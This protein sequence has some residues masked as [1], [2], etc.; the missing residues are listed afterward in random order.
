M[1]TEEIDFIKSFTKIHL[2]T[3]SRV[4]EELYKNEWSPACERL[5]IE[6]RNGIAY[7]AENILLKPQMNF[8]PLTRTFKKEQEPIRQ[9]IDN[10]IRQI[11]NEWRQLN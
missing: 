8:S 1:T 9:E 11:F 3:F 6:T 7:I 10:L 4:K 5:F 2:N